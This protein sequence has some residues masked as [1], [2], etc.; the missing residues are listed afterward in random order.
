ME[1][2]ALGEQLWNDW[3]RRPRGGLE[4][5]SVRRGLRAFGSH[6]TFS[7]H[8]GVYAECLGLVEGAQPRQAA[9]AEPLNL[10]VTLTTCYLP[11][12]RLNVYL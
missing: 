8:T 3:W 7:P 4:F 6:T 1:W 11:G 2:H 9:V 5:D 12:R 10:L